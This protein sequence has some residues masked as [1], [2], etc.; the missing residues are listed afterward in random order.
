MQTK[1]VSLSVTSCVLCTRSND[2]VWY[3]RCMAG[4]KNW[5]G[6]AIYS[7][8]YDE[9]SPRLT[10]VSSTMK[11]ATLRES[12]MHWYVKNRSAIPCL[13]GTMGFINSSAPNVPRRSHRHVL[14]TSWIFT[15]ELGAPIRKEDRHENTPILDHRVTCYDSTRSMQIQ[16]HVTSTCPCWSKDTRQHESMLLAPGDA[17]YDNTCISFVGGCFIQGRLRFFNPKGLLCSLL[18]AFQ[19]SFS[20]WNEPSWSFTLFLQRFHVVTSSIPLTVAWP[21]VR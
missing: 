1:N 16:R 11:P 8:L 10:K 2:T 14:A 12:F 17:L 3:S 4:C 13:K 6:F 5:I 15:L 19:T 20:A 7:A 18:V 21:L 9:N